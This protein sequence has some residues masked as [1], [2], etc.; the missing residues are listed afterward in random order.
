MYSCRHDDICIVAVERHWVSDDDICT[1]KVER[2]SDNDICI[3][4][5]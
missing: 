3:V 2:V 5:E 1:S 4:V